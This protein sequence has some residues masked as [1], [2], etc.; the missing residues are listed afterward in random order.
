MVR[1]PLR[2]RVA[3]L[4]LSL[5]SA[6]CGN[7]L[8]LP[9]GANPGGV[10]TPVDAGPPPPVID[11]RADGNRDGL[12]DLED[13]ADDLP[14]WDKTHGAVFLANIDDDLHA[15]AV[16]DA[17]GKPLSDEL[18]P[19]CNDAADEVINGADD[20][21]D[22]AP[23]RVKPWPLAPDGA[24][25]TLEISAPGAPYVR[26][27]KKDSSGK[28]VV[29]AAGAP[30]FTAAELRSGVELWIEGKD[31]VRD[32][33][34]WDGTVD[35]SL[36]VSLR[37]GDAAPRVLGQDFLRMRI[38]PVIT[39]HQLLPAETVYVT[40]IDGD[41]GSSEF[42]NDLK[43]AIGFSDHPA[44]LSEL[45]VD[46][47]WTQDFFETGYMS[48]PAPGR[49]QHVIRVNYRSANIEDRGTAFPLR[50]AGRLVFTKLRGKDVAGVQQYD[51]T[52]PD[53]MQSLNSF[54]NLETIP[55]YSFNGIEYPLGRVLRGNI[56][57]FHADARFVTLVEGQQV[58]P[59]VYVD[60]S[61]LLVGHVD[62]TLSFVP[63]STSRGWA[64]LANDPALARQMLEAEV[65]KGHGGVQMFVGRKL[66]D[67]NSDAELPAARSIADVLG[68]PDIMAQSAIAAAEVS[69]QLEIIKAATGLTDAEIVKVPF[70]HEKVQGE[71]LAYQPG[72]VNGL[73]LDAHNFLAPQPHGPQIDG[74]DPFQEQLSTAL[75]ALGIQVRWGEDWDLY[76]RN[77]GEVHCATNA[78]R[79]IPSTRWWETGR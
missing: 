69:G 1:P 6:A 71:S 68:D 61:W 19:Q 26:L 31:I 57:S 2:W 44:A 72:T 8:P 50:A 46:D 39:F 27:F 56:S 63:A 51:P 34:V 25:A 7:S 37:E 42:R 36:T 60:T 24:A 40:R 3:G 10:E 9:P 76:H 54:G 32:S 18:L 17:K 15:C 47:P 20:L 35:L 33:K 49:T 23:I 38:A 5:A 79:A 52:T 65:Q 74:K 53:E 70:L 77:D 16:T 62:E 75:A 43:K 29:F 21:L 22:L 4:V 41:S 30:P 78:A 59:P 13:P 73:V 48:M 11:L 28:P 58:Q 45:T 55:P 12:V 66:Y 14:G 64:L 67:P